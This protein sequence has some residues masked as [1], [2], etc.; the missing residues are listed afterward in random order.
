MIE[1]R[2]LVSKILLHY[3]LIIDGN[4]DIELNSGMAKSPQFIKPAIR[5]VKR[6]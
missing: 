6:N 4:D 3:Q 5:F 1:Q 2:I